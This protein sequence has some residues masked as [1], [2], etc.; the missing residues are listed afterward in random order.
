MTNTYTLVLDYQEGDFVVSIDT[1]YFFEA[2]DLT[3]AKVLGEKI[4]GQIDE[5]FQK[6]YYD[7]SK[8]DMVLEIEE[9][10]LF[11]NPSV[12]KYEYYDKSK[13]DYLTLDLENGKKLYPVANPD[14]FSNVDQTRFSEL[15]KNQ[16]EDY[17]KE[18]RKNILTF[19]SLSYGVVECK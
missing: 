14:C 19:G 9:N 3:E 17:F 13:G 12:S 4:N 11:E 18:E 16:Y 15:L 2:K 1:N 8:D 5:C 10:N 6:V 7:V